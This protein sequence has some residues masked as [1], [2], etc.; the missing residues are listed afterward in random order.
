MT[1]LV[2]AVDAVV[3]RNTI[4]SSLCE[5]KSFNIK[6]IHIVLQKTHFFAFCS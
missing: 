4:Q 1:D 5:K 2:E 3:G 6:H